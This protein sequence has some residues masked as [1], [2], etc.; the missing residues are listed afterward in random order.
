MSKT[1]CRNGISSHRTQI[2]VIIFLNFNKSSSNFLPTRFGISLCLMISQFGTVVVFL[3]L[4]SNNIHNLLK[5]FFNIDLNFCILILIFAACLL[6]VTMLK[7]PKDF[8]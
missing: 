8:W 5:S 6:P 1:L 3:L 7:S 2:Q 4:V